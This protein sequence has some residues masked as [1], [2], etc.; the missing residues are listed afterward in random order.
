VSAA[1]RTTRF[2]SGFL[3]IRIAVYATKSIAPTFTG[4]T[5]AMN[6]QT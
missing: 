6:G 4:G 2:T 5:A 3:E 1:G